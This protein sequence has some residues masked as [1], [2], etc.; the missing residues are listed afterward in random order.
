MD[1]YTHV[2]VLIYDLTFFP[3]GEPFKDPQVFIQGGI[4]LDA[5]VIFCH[6]VERGLDIRGF[7]V[8]KYSLEIFKR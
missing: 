4:G 2:H 5:F 3:D 7:Q 6:L 1:W 8:S